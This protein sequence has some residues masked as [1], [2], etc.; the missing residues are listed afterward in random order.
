MSVFFDLDYSRSGVGRASLP[1]RRVT[2]TFLNFAVCCNCIDGS[3]P[4]AHLIFQSR[5]GE[6]HDCCNQTLLL[7]GFI[8][9]GF[10]I[11]LHVFIEF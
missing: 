11:R 1:T 9:Q 3:I 5:R 2:A 10:Q 6:R 7:G 4:S 8:I